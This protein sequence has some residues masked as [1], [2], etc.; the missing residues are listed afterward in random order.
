MYNFFTVSVCAGWHP[1]HMPRVHD[2]NMEKEHGAI[3]ASISDGPPTQ[4]A[5]GGTMDIRKSPAEKVCGR[6]IHAL[7]GDDDSADRIRPLRGSR[8]FEDEALPV[9][10]PLPAAHPPLVSPLE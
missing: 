1:D 7:A 3:L 4:S 8:M 6:S 9:G 5:R 2:T 10:I